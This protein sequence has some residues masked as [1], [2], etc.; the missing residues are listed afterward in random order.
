MVL[1]FVVGASA[2]WCEARVRVASAAHCVRIRGFGIL[3]EV[4]G[5]VD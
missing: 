4:L 5:G 2:G 1:V 3:S